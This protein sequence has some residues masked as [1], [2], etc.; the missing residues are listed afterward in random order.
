MRRFDRLKDLALVLAVKEVVRTEAA[1]NLS[2]LC[3]NE[4]DRKHEENLAKRNVHESATAWQACLNSRALDLQKL[5][6]LAAEL[7][8]RHAEFEIANKKRAEAQR[9]T[10]QARAYYASCE[11]QVSQ[12]ELAVQR[13]RKKLMRRSEE[14][15]LSA[16]E[17]R[18]AYL[19]V[20]Q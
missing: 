6:Y 15:R 20:T 11:A 3:A 18:T 2:G 16:A 4:D 13:V 7:G 12:A 17:D 9:R 1:Q 5:T 10:E 14:R 19:R 8:V